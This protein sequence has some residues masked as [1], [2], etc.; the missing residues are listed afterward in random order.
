MSAITLAAPTKLQ[1]DTR[2]T[3]LAIAK[4]PPARV[5]QVWRLPWADT[6][7]KFG[8]AY[9]SMVWWS[10]AGGH[11]WPMKRGKDCPCGWQHTAAS[12]RAAKVLQLREHVLWMDLHRSFSHQASHTTSLPVSVQLLPRTA[13]VAAS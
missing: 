5:R 4:T 10:R 6:G 2:P 7:R 8:G 3:A 13:C 1:E 12:S 9:S 11:G